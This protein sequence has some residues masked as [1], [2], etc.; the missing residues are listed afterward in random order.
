MFA[1]NELEFDKKAALILVLQNM[2]VHL[3]IDKST[4]S[5][6]DYTFLKSWPDIML[7]LDTVASKYELK[8]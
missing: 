4:V 2:Q 8:K 6:I 1:I 5:W 3:S 7:Y